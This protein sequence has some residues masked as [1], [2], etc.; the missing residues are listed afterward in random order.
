MHIVLLLNTYHVLTRLSQKMA[1]L[2]EIDVGS[3]RSRLAQEADSV[4]LGPH[5]VVPNIL[6]R[7]R[8]A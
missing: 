2:K 5:H 3:P 6:S 8:C 7:L 4:S 1:D